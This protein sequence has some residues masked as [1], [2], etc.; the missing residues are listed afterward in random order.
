MLACCAAMELSSADELPQSRPRRF[1]AFRSDLGRKRGLLYGGGEGLTDY[2]DDLS[3]IG[4]ERRSAGF[5]SDLGKRGL[6][7]R[8]THAFRS[9]LGKRYADGDDDAEKRFAFRSDLGKRA[10][11]RHDLGKRFDA[12]SKKSSA[13]RSDLGKR[14]TAFRSDLGRR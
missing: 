14:L 5:R 8:L 6:A 9:D 11:F 12:A 4:A 2:G 7:K 10:A 3:E 1:S 13:F